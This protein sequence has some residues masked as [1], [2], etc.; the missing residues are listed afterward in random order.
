[1]DASPSIDSA[2]VALVEETIKEAGFAR[3]LPLDHPDNWASIQGLCDLYKD[4]I[5]P[6]TVRR[7]LNHH[8]ENGL[9][10]MG[11]TTRRGKRLRV[12]LNCTK[13]AAP[14]H[15]KASHSAAPIG[16]LGCR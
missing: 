8:F 14:H 9:H 7:Y 15:T 1:M 2:L 11:A 10:E 6:D 13:K 5:P 12:S 16:F 3:P 4:K